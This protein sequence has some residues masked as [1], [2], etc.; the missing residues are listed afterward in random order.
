MT[1]TVEATKPDLGAIK[2]RQQQTWASGDFAVVA[3]RIVLVAERL[4]DTADLQAGWRV[5]D[6]ATGSG[7][8]AIAAARH[9]CT[10][11]GVDYVPSL[12][13]RGRLR[14]AAEGLSVELLEGDAESLPFPDASFD[15]VTSVFGSMFAPDHGKTAAELLRVCRPGG[16][17][18][19]ASWRP[20]GL[21]G[22]LF[23]TVGAHVPP[24]AGLSSPL[25][26]GTEGHLRE[27]LGESIDSLEVTERTFAF[28]FLSAE[29]FVAFFRSWYGPTLKALEAL[30][31]TARDE[32]ERDLVALARR[33][34]RLESDAVAIPATYTEAVAI[35]R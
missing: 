23:R 2:Q 8:A 29:D 20:E 9:G 26:W 32:L 16:T 25:L 10:A 6:V 14:A 24:P 31:G 34:D 33:F 3:A 15:A 17:I 19:L 22:E 12:L 21:I 30:E 28:R 27:L 13:E 18:A 5:L 11:V 1:S 35:R 7:N 4:C